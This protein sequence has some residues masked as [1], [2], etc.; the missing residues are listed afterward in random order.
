VSFAAVPFLL[1]ATCLAAPSP[2]PNDK[3]GRTSAVAR[4]IDD[5]TIAAARVDLTLLEPK[6]VEAWLAEVAK[7]GGADAAELMKHLGEGRVAAERWLADFRK[8][9]GREIYFV[10]SLADLPNGPPLMLVPLGAGANADA[11]EGLLAAGDAAAPPEARKRLHFDRVWNVL[12]ATGN[13]QA[14]ERARAIK[15][16]DRPDLMKALDAGGDAAVTAAAAPSADS[17]RAL[18]ELLPKLPQ[19]VG[20]GPSTVVTRGV[21]WANLALRP[22]PNGSLKLVVQSKDPEA[23]KALGALVDGTVALLAKVA[24]AEKLEGMEPLFAALKPQPEGD[25]LVLA[26]DDQGLRQVVASL[27]AGPTRRARRNAQWAVSSNNMRQ[28]LLV[29][30]MWANEKKGG[31]PDDLAKA[32]QQY[33]LPPTVLN[34]P[35]RPGTG[36]TYHKPSAKVQNSAEVIVLHD[37]GPTDGMRNVGFMDGRVEQMSEEAFQQ[38]LKAGKEKK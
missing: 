11:L 30:H 37:A 14:L 35:L 27:F 8:A 36:Y 20:G 29:C 33:Q 7:G 17:R 24:A 15:A 31:W 28:I 10:M 2:G 1:V 38:Q 19:E 5:Q 23:A 9:G 22:P 16:V 25:Q 4:F 18:E 13:R 26:L 21:V 12:L 6:A 32:T 3:A 34:N